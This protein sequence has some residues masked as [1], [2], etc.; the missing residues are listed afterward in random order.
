MPQRNQMTWAEL[1]VGILV[2]FGAALVVIAMFYVTGFGLL[3]PKYRL[4]TY[5]PEVAGLTVGA[6]VRVDG[7]DVGNVDSLGI[8]PSAGQGVPD[9]QRNIVLVL[10]IDKKY[11]N[12]IR[13]DSKAGLQTQGLLGDQ[14]VTI[15]RGFKG[16]PLQDNQE[17][18]GHGEMG[19][20]ELLAQGASL[21]EHLNN[22]SDQVEGLVT[23]VRAGKGTLGKFVT[24][25]SAYNY[26]ESVA[27]RTDDVLANIQAGQGTFGKLYASDEVHQKFLGMEDHVNNI[28]DAVQQQKGSFGKFIYDPSLHDSAKDFLNKSNGFVDDVRGGKGTL[29]KLVTDDSLFSTW[30]QTGAN[31][32][33]AT[34]KLNGEDGTAGK[35]F[36][37]PKLYDNLAGLSGDMRLLMNDFRQNPKKFLR[38]KFS[39][40]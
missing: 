8:N 33:S 32:S 37:D 24:D 7:I 23:D 15:S 12:D 19:M 30:K 3:Q 35:L 27:E 36:S 38:V 22:L 28:L 40:F 29:G 21:A 34:A 4:R 31:L 6:P 16:V 17:I 5:L 1:R 10:R 2:I 18:S 14:Y 39:I 20:T 9:P 13:S 25:D 11:Q 26:F